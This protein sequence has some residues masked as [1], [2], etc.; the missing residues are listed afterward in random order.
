MENK[1]LV[2]FNSQQ[3]KLARLASGLTFGDIG[4][5]LDVTRQYASKLENGAIPSEE[6]L[7]VLSRVLSVEKSFFFKHRTKVIESEQC[8]FRSL[9]TSTQK[10]KK[11]IMAQV[12][13]LDSAIVSQL[14][15]EIEFPEVNIYSAS[16]CEFDTNIS[17]EL[18][19]E[20]VRKIWGLGLGPI[21]NMIRLLESVGCIVVNLSDADERIDA[22]SIHGNRPIVVRNTS[23]QSPGRMRFDFAHELGHLIMH[24][25]IETGC[26]LTE[27]QA[28]NF[29]SAFLLPRSSFAAEFPKIRGAYLNW[30]ALIQMKV[31]WGVSLKALIFRA[32][33]LGLLSDE[34]AKSAYMYL[35]KNGYTK[36]ERGD[37]LMFH[38]SPSLLQQALDI[39]DPHTSQSILDEAGLNVSTLASRY[40]LKVNVSPLKLVR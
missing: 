10:L 30:E 22:F 36:N 8:H 18:L 39:L 4:E 28:N 3:L 16:E 38:E 35:A 20:K 40:S 5:A 24:E 15:G 12:E 7:V 14:D 6:Q 29:A 26:R 21:S 9:R 31:R 25:G 11:T 33:T 17:I 34:K 2:Q 37:E 23:K 19:A 32:R 27:Q 13:M 1:P